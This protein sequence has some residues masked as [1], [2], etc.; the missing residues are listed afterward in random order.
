MR[1]ISASQIGTFEDCNRFWW[2]ERILRLLEPPAIVDNFTFGTVLHGVCER[3]LS[4]TMNGRVRGPA[5]AVMTK[6]PMVGQIAGHPVNLYPKG[7]ETTVERDGSSGKTVTP[8]EAKLIQRLIAE[9]IEEGILVRGKQ[10]TVERKI[11]LPV[12]EGVNLVGYID[13]HRNPSAVRQL[14]VIEDHKSYGKGSVRFLKREKKTSPNFLGSDQQLKTYAWAITELDNL[15]DSVGGFNGVRVRHN[16][17][18]KFP[19]RPVTS[20]E[21]TITSEQI[22]EHGEYLRDVAGRMVRVA[23]VKEWAD[24]PGPKDTG[25]CEHWY[26][27]P[28]PFHKICGRVETTEQHKARV[29]R[30]IDSQSDK[31]RL[32]LPL[33]SPRKRTKP[34]E[35]NGMSSIFDK[36][37]KK[38][39]AQAARKKAAGSTAAKAKAKPKAKAPATPVNG[40]EPAQQE[41]AVVGGAPW[42]NPSCRACKGRG[43]TSKGKA[44]PICDNT[45]K[46]GGRPTSMSYVLELDDEELGVAVAR[47]ESV[48]GLEAAGLPLEWI[49]ADGPAEPAKTAV[50]KAPAE[51]PQEPADEESEPE[52]S[53]GT[54]DNEAQGA[55][56]QEPEAPAEQAPAKGTR[57][58]KNAKGAGRPAAGLTILVGVVPL[59]GAITS[60][61]VVTSAEVLAR[62]G[63]ELAKDMGAESYYDLDSFKRRDRLAQGAA[64]IVAELNRVVLVHPGVLGN[65]DVGALVQALM[66]QTEGIDAIY[67]RTS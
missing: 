61:T 46:K 14:P 64:H 18:P 55:Q 41:P 19:G 53:E 44:C 7:W 56:E 15:H 1:T 29:S 39:A 67:V 25:K 5:G 43:L 21:A 23:D 20:V 8:T 48:E 16:Q 36:A 45:A 62:F 50:S 58:R 22:E 6:E 11:L 60:R 51:T 65:D 47:S 17:Y 59:R 24:V 9:A 42:A 32:D 30:L 49:E 12:I 34:K 66:G 57:K 3:Y 54:S 33:Q 38:K 26:G 40:S 27:K 13:V 28:C 4:A 52:A 63:A 2:F 31:P 35:A 37:K 10:T